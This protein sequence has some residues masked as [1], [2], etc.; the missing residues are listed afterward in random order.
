MIERFLL[1][2][3]AVSCIGLF[4]SLLFH[5]WIGSQVTEK[6]ALTFV[7]MSIFAYLPIRNKYKTQ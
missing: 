3:F 2:F 7:V 6:I 5:I 4:A 1:A